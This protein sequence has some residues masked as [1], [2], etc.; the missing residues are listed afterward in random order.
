MLVM[1]VFRVIKGAILSLNI[2]AIAKIAQ[3]KFKKNFFHPLHNTRNQIHL[4][5]SSS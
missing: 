3:Y 2:I 5:N 4:F 1:K